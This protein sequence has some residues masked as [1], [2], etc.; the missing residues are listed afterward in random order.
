MAHTAK[1]GV[2]RSAE[3]PASFFSEP[4]IDPFVDTL[5][6][7]RTGFR[8]GDKEGGRIVHISGLV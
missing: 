2:S 4:D 8:V 7:S 6:H 1:Y 5:Q 3:A